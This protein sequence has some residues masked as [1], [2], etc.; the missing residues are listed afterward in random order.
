MYT[1][2]LDARN[3]TANGNN[4]PG[5]ASS[6][7]SSPYGHSD[8]TAAE[9]V[10]RTISGPGTNNSVSD[11]SSAPRSRNPSRLAMGPTA[12]GSHG[13]RWLGGSLSADT[14]GESRGVGGHQHARQ[15]QLPR[16]R[17]AD[18][19]W[20]RRPEDDVEAWD[21]ITTFLRT[22]TP[23][24]TN[25]MSVPTEPYSPSAIS[26]RSS[27]RRKGSRKKQG[28]LTRLLMFLKGRSR[29]KKPVR[30]TSVRASSPSVARTTSHKH[31]R[32]PRIKLPDTAISGRTVGGHR[33]IAISIPIEYDHLTPE[34]RNESRFPN[35]RTTSLPSVERNPVVHNNVNV[36]PMSA[37]ANEPYVRIHP[38]PMAQTQRSLASRPRT[39]EGQRGQEDTHNPRLAPRHTFGPVQEDVS[40]ANMRSMSPPRVPRR[41]SDRYDTPSLGRP[42][43]SQASDDLRNV[44]HRETLAALS[45]PR[46]APRPVSVQ[47]TYSF[48]S[49]ATPSPSAKMY[50][51]MREANLHS[52]PINN[53]QPQ[54]R[55]I[56][57]QRGRNPHSRESSRDKYTLQESVFSERSFLESMGTVE[58]ASETETGVVAAGTQARGASFPVEN[59]HAVITPGTSSEKYDG[60]L[61]EKGENR[62]GKSNLATV[63]EKGSSSGQEIRRGSGQESEKIPIWKRRGSGA[64]MLANPEM[65]TVEAH[66][67]RKS[68]L[69]DSVEI[70]LETPTEAS[71]PDKMGESSG[72]GDENDHK[73]AG[74]GPS[75][76]TESKDKGKE[77]TPE[78]AP[79]LKVPGESKGKKPPSSL[80]ST[81]QRNRRRKEILLSREQR[82][83]E[84]RKKL[85][86]PGMEPK[87]L[88]WRRQS[89]SSSDGSSDEGHSTDEGTVVD[90]TTTPNDV[91]AAPEANPNRLEATPARF[92]LS[93]VMT[94]ADV[95]PSSGGTA[96]PELQVTSKES[97]PLSASSCA[98][99]AT[100]IRASPIP[101]YQSLASV[102]P[103]D[104]P[105]SLP[106]SH[107][108]VSS[109]EAQPRETP[110]QHPPPKRLSSPR[111]RP[112]TFGT[113]PHVSSGGR[114]PVVED[115]P[116]QPRTSSN[117]LRPSSFH[118]ER[119]IQEGEHAEGSTS[120]KKAPR[121]ETSGLYDLQGEEKV[122]DMER[123]LAKLE[124]YRDHW[125]TSMIPLLTDMGQ[126]LGELATSNEKNKGKEVDRSPR[127]G[128]QPGRPDTSDSDGRKSRLWRRDFASE[129]AESSTLRTST[130]DDEDIALDSDEVIIRHPQPPYAR[131]GRSRAGTNPN[132]STS[133]PE[134]S[135][136]PYPLD[137][138]AVRPG[139]DPGRDVHGDFAADERRAR[140]P[141]YR[142]GGGRLRR[143]GWTMSASMPP[144]AAA[145]AISRG[146]VPEA[147]ALPLP[148]GLREEAGRLE[149]LERRNRRADD[150]R[151]R[152]LSLGGRTA[153]GLGG[154]MA[155]F[156]TGPDGYVAEAPGGMETLEGLM[157][158]LQVLRR[159]LG[160]MGR[161]DAGHGDGVREAPRAVV[162]FGAF[163]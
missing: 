12:L 104:S 18:R 86:A 20:L 67:V 113:Q 56:S 163:K 142:E 81:K 144:E 54:A 148:M 125:V 49:F 95:K 59:V 132:T 25:F 112:S 3:H 155:G 158:E 7:S 101:P 143:R 89:S 11:N 117:G 19:R 42:S 90:E 149:R 26:S 77:S 147:L 109:V 145:R 154:G 44:A 37:F 91:P 27:I 127:A 115:G 153:R 126:T 78:G 119:H 128:M 75:K 118:N 40:S 159:R 34:P 36:R 108:P 52:T 68:Q 138:A 22:V 160:K 14:R 15:R 64:I 136:W 146:T 2:E 17:S 105:H 41:T 94:V 102:T 137:K 141:S 47:S 16:L 32:P 63:Q 1:Y 24:P 35:K 156:E 33:H 103:P 55:N 10:Q 130:E 62:G 23:P 100:V 106:I 71:W 72:E 121:T 9:S 150:A 157:K 74:D 60:D 162:G 39:R 50:Y 53:G 98:T 28:P 38:G 124:R 61:S 107:S 161:V 73:D 8:T 87:D 21:E 80:P 57:N 139:L 88:I 69:R 76:E 48:R 46:T 123:R 152:S 114:S 29:R 133:E 129:D 83:A 65:K 151:M 111:R 134:R 116:S 5:S 84:L 31:K 96:S 70:V 85:E 79:M 30:K 92:S 140:S 122:Q 131:T 99:M 66:A 45:R 58:S 43:T 51:P 13:S 93:A 82:I 120:I 110:T 4:R 135:R 97:I 6:S